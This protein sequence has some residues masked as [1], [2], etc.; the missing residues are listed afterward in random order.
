MGDHKAKETKAAWTK[1]AR[2]NMSV[3]QE[4]E[5]SKRVER[6]ISEKVE[7]EGNK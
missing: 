2:E 3:F 6:K 1:A 4:K 5:V 7:R